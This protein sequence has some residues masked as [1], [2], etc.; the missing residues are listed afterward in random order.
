M[1]PG[2]RPIGT[3]AARLAALT[4]ADPQQL[5]GSCTTSPATFGE[6]CR[7]AVAGSDAPL[8]IAIDQAEE[9]FTQC[10]DAAEREAFAT[11]LAQRV[12]R[13][14][15]A[16]RARRLRRALHHPRRR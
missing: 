7:T 4:H 1:T 13:A 9:L 11:A 8:V 15:R 2:E 14:G 6:L 10:A 5:A 3:L 16:R 12:A